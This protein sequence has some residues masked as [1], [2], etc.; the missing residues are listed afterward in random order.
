M[1][2]ATDD[3]RRPGRK[4]R[5]AGL[6]IAAALLALTVFPLWFLTATTPGLGLLVRMAVPVAQSTA[7]L[8]L[9]V[10]APEGSLWSRVTARHVSISGADG[11]AVE[12]A[13]P[14]IGWRP[15]ALLSARVEIDEIAAR[16]IG[17]ALPATAEPGEEEAAPFALPEMPALAIRLARLD[18]PEIHIRLP[19]DEGDLRLAAQ[20]GLNHRADGVTE[21][22]LDLRPTDGGE[23][24]I[25]LDAELAGASGNLALKTHA[26]MTPDGAFARLAGLDGM[27][28]DRIT[29][30]I[31][32][33]GPLE[34]WRGKI[35]LAH[36]D[37]VRWRSGFGGALTATPVIALDGEIALA[38]PLSLGLP[39]DFA[40]TYRNRLQIELS[41]D[42]DLAIRNIDIALPGMFSLTGDIGHGAGGALS[43]NLDLQA[44][45]ALAGAFDPGIGYT[46]L[47]LSAGLG[48]SV[49][50]PELEV[51]ASAREFDL[52]GMLRADL[53]VDGK[54]ALDADG[55]ISSDLNAALAGIAWQEPAAAQIVG[56]NLSLRLSAG[57]PAALDR[58]AITALHLDARNIT[59]RGSADATI[60]GDISSGTFTLGLADLSHL[61]ELAGLAL[62]GSTEITLSE[63]TGNAERGF[64]G[65][66]AIDGTGIV[67][68]DAVVD[69]LIGNPSLRTGIRLAGFERLVLNGLTLTTAGLR[70]DGDIAY[71][72]A[73]GGLSAALNGK[74]ARTALPPMDGV[75][76]ASDP[77]FR[78]DLKGPA[79]APEGTV[80][81][82]LAGADAAGFAI[83]ATRLST[84]LGWA[85]SSPRLDLDL[86][87]KLEGQ[88]LRA[89]TSLLAANDLQFRDIT[90][91]LP[92]IS[93]TGDITLPA[94]APP[95]TGKLAIAITDAGGLSRLTAMNLALQSNLSASLTAKEGRQSA[96]VAGTIRDIRLADADVGIGS[97]DIRLAL[98]DLLGQPVID[99]QV[100]ASRI[101][102]ADAALANLTASARGTAAALDWS[103]NG[104]GEAA[105]KPVSANLAGSVAQTG[106]RIRIALDNGKASFDKLEAT[107]AEPVKL[108]MVNGAPASATGTLGLA[109][110][111]IAASYRKTGKDAALELEGSAIS[112]APLLA[113]A[114]QQDVTGKAGF[115]IALGEKAGRTTGDLK[116]DLADIRTP[117][118][119]VPAGLTVTGRLDDGR[120]E[121][122]GAMSGIDLDSASV[123]AGL[124]AVISLSTPSAAFPQ[125]GALKADVRFT[126]D[127]ARIWPLLPL[128]EHQMTGRFDI[129]ATADG[130]LGNPELGGT[131]RITDGEYEHL[132]FGSRLT[133]MALDARFQ[134][135][136]LKLESFKAGDGAGG[137]VSAEGEAGFADGGFDY[138]FRLSATSARLLHRDDLE[139]VASAD[140]RAEGDATAGRIEG[141]ITI[142]KAE[143]NLAAALPP[144]V[145]TLEIENDP[146]QAEKKE[147]AGPTYPLDLD[148]RVTVPGKTFVR[149]RG[150]DSEWGGQ[151]AVAGTAAEPAITGSIRAVRGQMDVVGKVFNIRDSAVTF[152]GGIEPRLDIAGLYETKDLEVTARLAGPARK[153]ELTLSSSPPMPR[154]EILAQVLFGQGKASLGPLQAA[155]L[156]AAAADL[157]GAT[158]GGTDVIGRIRKLAGVDV[159]RVEDG[160]SGPAVAAGKYIADGVYVGAKQGAKPGSGGVE[161]EVEVTPNISVKSEAGQ[162]GDSNIGVQFKWDY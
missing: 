146:S 65:R 110:G 75:S 84:R 63:L 127:I 135:G 129:D 29:L 86:R 80:T 114:G 4:T 1:G 115:T 36:G 106:E 88:E 44:T 11:L 66:L 38:D 34:K 47:F 3:T 131:A 95:A 105:G 147:A 89:R 83:G 149:G 94:S 143:I 82:D 64:E 12:I 139:A 154:D 102:A 128:P 24:A 40:G 118:L 41:E 100:E 60:A 35:D 142:E 45:G 111:R 158:G 103:L 162:T 150:L 123:R 22:R 107:I 136:R 31:D 33:D 15:L 125:D 77:A 153:P 37:R 2:D 67:T 148:I 53:T 18:L 121:I 28:T 16:R 23:D 72:I 134:G 132:E 97:A 30:V 90:L 92:G 14:A 124:P 7:G 85:S 6:K 156:A 157:S 145:T 46:E 120:L 71:N 13:E 17:L 52:P 87:S 70:L 27:L 21:A 74:V 99:A 140:I 51:A 144:S 151:I 55:A 69:G 155:Q 25:R 5:F 159:L 26:T 68:G 91:T 116:L 109:G 104:S 141:D 113:A 58:V 54:L 117:A 9:S 10:E 39:R 62:Q 98:A 130:T 20:G 61:E 93:L 50:K 8:R 56:D 101:V 57:S 42:G 43:G 19:E 119:P 133:G 96:N 78:I 73:D 122:E 59:L 138:R 137:A 49:A 79:T 126:G 112:L 76:L 161:V 160:A 152:S 32:G 81:L 48:G 108:E